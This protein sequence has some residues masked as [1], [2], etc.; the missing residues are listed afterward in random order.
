MQPGAASL[1]TWYHA[2]PAEGNAG[3]AGLRGSLFTVL[4]WNQVL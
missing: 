1:A 4:A 2:F 3:K